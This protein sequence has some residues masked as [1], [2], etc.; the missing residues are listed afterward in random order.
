V[1]AG[2]YQ[3]ATIKDLSKATDDFVTIFENG[4]IVFDQLLYK[5]AN[6]YLEYNM[7]KVYWM[8]RE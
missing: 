8:F 4:L 3:G 2:L 5:G 7:A 6:Q 1:T